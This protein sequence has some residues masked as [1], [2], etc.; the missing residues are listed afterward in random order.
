MKLLF[1]HQNFPGQFK[2]FAHFC[3]ASGHEVVGLGAGQVAEV[4][5]MRV[6]GYTLGRGNA[7]GVHTWAQEFESK[8][9]RG[10]ACA[11]ALQRL[12]S[13]GFEPDVI[14]AHPGWGEALFVKAVFP[15]AKLVCLME[16]YYRLEGQ[17]MG[18]DP[19]FPV[20]SLEDQA[21]LASK[22]ANLLLAMEAMDYGVSPTPWQASTLPTWVGD[23]LRL[24]HEGI[25]TSLCRP[26]V[27]AKIALPDRGVEIRPGDE[28]L[29]FVARNLEPVRGYHVFMRALPEIMARRPN[30][31]VFIVGGDGVSYG[32]AP[33]GG[34]YRQRYLMEVARRLDPQRVF[35]LGNVQYGVFLQLMQIT[36]C[37]VYLTYPFVLSWSML[38]AMSAG[39]LVVGSRTSPVMDAI[40]DGRNGLLVDFFDVAGLA[41]RVCDVLAHPE[42]YDGMRAV[43]RQTVLERF[44]LGSV[45]L[46]AYARLLEECAG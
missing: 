33:E 3:Q 34:S 26:N 24:I 8:V 45:C 18:F 32:G 23:K 25:D 39:A 43:A 37:H 11:L 30:V 28:V 6:F 21:R 17:D 1:V 14:F 16:Y 40:E 2:H 13:A 36:R 29:T 19:E 20:M 46:P 42:R 35:F 15:R 12:K 9:I 22:N 10:E 41:D 5:G 7:P 38:E 4:E 44:D 27:S 31:K